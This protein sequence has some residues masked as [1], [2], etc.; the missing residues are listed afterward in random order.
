MAKRLLDIK[1]NHIFFTGSKKVGKLIYQKAA[2]QFTTVT[3]ELGGK[4]PIYVD[5]NLSIKAMEKA[6]SR[7]VWGK[8]IN[9]GQTCVAPDYIILHENVHELFVTTFK[10]VYSQ[11]FYKKFYDK[12]TNTFN[13]DINNL[14][15][16][17]IPIDSI[18]QLLNKDQFA[19]LSKLLENTKGQIIFGG[20]MNK[21]KNHISLTL[22]DNVQLNDILMEDEIFG[23]IFPIIR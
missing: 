20:H 21:H 12:L 3:L 15:E 19:R 1:F 16:N 6:C 11:R 23:P 2:E 14:D 10:K 5:K 18:G 9:S 13:Y 7:I 8:M 22:V 17:G 4:S